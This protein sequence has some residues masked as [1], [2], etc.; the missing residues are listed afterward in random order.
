MLTSIKM[1][2]KSVCNFILIAVLFVSLSSVVSA[3]IEFTLTP[4]IA[5]EDISVQYNLTVNNSNAGSEANISKVVVSFEVFDFVYGTNDT[6]SVSEFSNSTIGGFVFLNWTNLTGYVINGSSVNHF[7]FNATGLLS[8]FQGFRVIAI[9]GSG[10]TMKDVLVEVKSSCDAYANITTC[11]DVEGCTWD[12]KMFDRCGPSC[13]DYNNSDNCQ[14]TGGGYCMWDDMSPEPECMF[15][16]FSQK[17]FGCNIEDSATCEAHANCTW[18][19]MSSECIVDC[20]QYDSFSGGN[21]TTCESAY[22]GSICVWEEDWYCKDNPNA[23]GCEND[24]GMCDPFFFDKGFEGFSPCFG[25]DGNKSGCSTMTE[26]CVWFSKPDCIVGDWCYDSEGSDHGFCNPLGGFDFGGDFDCWLH[27]GNKDACKDAIEQSQWPCSWSPDSWGALINGTEA[28]WC[29][30]IFGG[31]GS[32]GG[33][34]WDYSFETDCNSAVGLGLPCEWKNSTGAECQEKGCWDYWDSSTCL[35]NQNDSCFWNDDYNYCYEKRCWDLS[36][37]SECGNAMVSYGQDCSWINNSW[38]DGGKCDENGC[39]SRDWTNDTYC[40]AKAGCYWDGSSHCFEKGCW[41]YTGAGETDCLNKTLNGLNCKWNDDVTGWCEQQGC[42]SYDDTNETACENVTADFGMDCTWDDGTHCYE[43]IKACVDQDNE[44]ACFGTGYCTWNGTVCNEPIGFQTQTFWNPGCWVFDQ[45][46]QTKCDNVT[47][48]NWTAGACI[49]DGANDNQGVQCTDINDSVMC[50]NIPMLSTCCQWNGTGC[51]D[52]PMVSTCHDLKEPPVGAMFCEDYN[53]KYSETLCDEIA[54]DPWYMPCEWDNSTEECSFA[55]DNMFGG[56]AGEFD[57]NDIGSKANCEASGGNWKEEKWIDESGNVYWDN[58]CETKIGFGTQSCNDAC[59]ACE[60]QNNGSF[61]ST[62]N[63]SRGAC[64]QSKSGCVYREDGNAFN[65]FGWCDM[66]FNKQGNCD[67]NCWECWDSD[68][69]GDSA[70]GCKWFTDPWDD[71]YG[72][73]DDKNVKTCDNDCFMCWDQQNCQAS[74]VGCSWD[75]D[76]YF[77]QP[78]GTGENG[79]S[80]EVCFDGVDNDN[81]NFYDCADPEC[82]FNAFCGGSNVFGSDCMSIPDNETCLNESKHAGYNCTWVADNWGNEWCDM[83]GAQCW[84]QDDNATAC[85]LEIGCQYKTMNDF[86]KADEE[87]CDINF[88]IMDSSQC[89]EKGENAS[90]CNAEAGCAWQEDDWCVEHPEDDWCV[91]MNGTAGWCDHELWSCNQY[92]DNKTACDAVDNACGWVDDWWCTTPE[93]EN[94]TW[95]DN[96]PGFCDPICFSR[97]SSVCNASVI[98]NGSSTDNVCQLLN[99]TDMGWCEPTNMFKGCWDYDDNVTACNL[100]NASCAWVEDPHMPQGGFCGD[101]F[102]QQMTGD[103]DKSP[104]FYFAGE[105]CVSG[106][107][108]TKDICEIGLKDSP[109]KFS[110]VTSVF[111]MTDSVFCNNSFEFDPEFTGNKSSRFYWYL[112]TDGVRTGGCSATDNS[113]IVGLEFKF[114]H[115]TSLANG[116]VS[117]IKVAYKCLNGTWSPSQIQTNVWPEKMCYM[118][119]G[120]VIAI[121]KEDIEKLNGYFDETAD[122]RIYA[123]TGSDTSPYDTAGPKEYTPNTAD[124]KFEDCGGLSDSDGDGY[125]P[126]ED[127]DCTDFLRNGY[128]DVEKGAQCGDGKDNDGN[129]LTDCLDSSC[130]QETSQDG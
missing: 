105:D 27:D 120:G 36:N 115:E 85:G 53:S 11:D 82:M 26:E 94:D 80:F 113:S 101:L 64:E 34:C 18:E 55:G 88:S 110:L 60:Q 66:D 23:T 28:G 108:A 124:F 81:D 17:T 24:P 90:V 107:N 59:W 45:A 62:G 15:M 21:I 50:N 57:M 63:A 84:T 67:G 22:G 109:D 65:G 29:N 52:A 46:G 102:M 93:G 61:W 5:T 3:D 129:G 9:N 121:N 16:P 19:G 30:M 118:F 128:V 42:W 70:A 116:E 99:S 100:A 32:S 78:S 13:E 117:E 89:W 122:M 74:S 73:C 10:E 8:G 98:I 58:W 127:P 51:Q 68:L 97:N 2:M 14:N 48:C 77:C 125:L 49:D 72:W 39:W 86:G 96:D 33:S 6:D 56:D 103:M 76:S 106:D 87:I 31:G 4:S 71:D 95:C 75:T 91:E 112:D 123:V 37:E 114:K 130:M 40:E 69:C 35:A 104:P 119:G 126:S 111:S 92:N 47:S 44:F 43:Q 20:F 79:E 1:V 41:D 25:F 12:D 54:G 83:P 38:G 7:L